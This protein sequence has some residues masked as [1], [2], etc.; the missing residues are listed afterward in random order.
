MGEKSESSIQDMPNVCKVQKFTTSAVPEKGLIRGALTI[1]QLKT[2]RFKHLTRAGFLL[3]FRLEGGSQRDYTQ[4]ISDR[5]DVGIHRESSRPP[6]S[7]LL[8]GKVSLCEDL[9]YHVQ[10]RLWLLL[11]K[12]PDFS[13]M[14][15]LAN[16]LS[17]PFSSP[18]FPVYSLSTHPP[19]ASAGSW[20]NSL[21]PSF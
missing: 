14:W 10:L 4:G 20:I 18:S 3:C 9:T 2:A 16:S 19:G 6:A 1:Q 17:A 7:H 12:P 21:P 5:S 13:L 8:P 11:S 15:S